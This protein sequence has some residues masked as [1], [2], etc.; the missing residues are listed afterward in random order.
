LKVDLKTVREVFCGVLEGSMTSEVADR[1]AN[2]LIHAR[3][4]GDLIFDPPCD[5][6]SI[7]A[8]LMYLSGV[9]LM[10]APGQY[11]HSREDI[12][13]AMNERVGGRE[14]TQSQGEK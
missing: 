6:A 10:V 4:L 9:D 14:Q 1:W 3:E 11:L 7:W 2:S 8:G 5:K 12:Q 13:I